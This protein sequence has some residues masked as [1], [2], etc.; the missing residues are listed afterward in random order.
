MN[1]S[2]EPSP[3]AERF[4]RALIHVDSPERIDV[5][6]VRALVATQGV[7]C[8]R[9][10][11]A[12]ESIAT[13]L[14][15]ITREFDPGADRKHDPTDTEATRRNFQKLQIG[16]NSGTSTSRTLGRFMRVL[17]N[18]IFAADVL[19]MRGHFVRLARIRNRLH[20][21]RE[22]FAIAGDEDG[23][24]TC[25]RIQQYPRGG[26]FM[27][28][29]RD[30]YSQFATDDAGLGY[31]QLLLLLT[32]QGCEYAQGGAYVELD[33][34]RFSYEQHC[35]RGDVVVYDGRSIHG[36]ADIDPMHALEL[37]RFGG[38]AVAI[39]SLFRV[40]RAGTAA[41][42]E[43]SDAAVRRYGAAAPE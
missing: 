19:G 13:T 16:A 30:L 12:P 39:A 31:F 9:G 15:R 25:A 34:E 35:L 24:W 4:A 26:G 33:G 11:F 20:G 29:H 43:L 17:Y 10:L 3:S 22:D 37:D 41:Y 23:F 14:A 21:L 28:P 6:A 1:A 40:L 8:L 27:V 36:V 32:E 38:R 5:E 7:A 2:A 42:G 18:P